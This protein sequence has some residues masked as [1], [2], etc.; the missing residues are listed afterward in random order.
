MAAVQAGEE[1]PAAEVAGRARAERTI[2]VFHMVVTLA[3]FQFSGWLNAFAF[4]R[5]E[6]KAW[7]VRRHAG[8]ERKGVGIQLLRLLWQG[9]RGVHPKHLAHGCD[10]GGIPARHV[11]VES[12]FARSAV[13]ELL[14]VRHSGYIPR[15]NRPVRRLCGRLVAT[16]L[17]E[18]G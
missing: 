13:Y 1:D 17:S 14:H 4:C 3:V 8:P 9:K 7:G 18:R 6:R 15:P 16:E 10:A 5:V 12:F 11:R 2:N